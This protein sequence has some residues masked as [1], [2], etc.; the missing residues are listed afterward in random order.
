MKIQKLKSKLNCVIIIF[1]GLVLTINF[2]Q[3]VILDDSGSDIKV[4]TF[5]VL[6]DVLG[7]VFLLSFPLFIIG[8]YKL[9]KDKKKKKE[10]FKIISL[11]ID[12]I[13]ASVLFCA[14]SYFC[15]FVT[16]FVLFFVL[17]NILGEYANSL[18]MEISPILFFV[19]CI[20]G[21]YWFWRKLLKLYKLNY[22]IILSIL[23]FIFSVSAY[24]LVF[25]AA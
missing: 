21:F 17:G 4:G 18:L 9:Y 10:K 7:I 5:G 6:H 16:A 12:A 23:F 25:V 24:I 19:V 14:F 3:A 15:I 11:I 13:S 2:A 1:L 22:F 8:A 20:F